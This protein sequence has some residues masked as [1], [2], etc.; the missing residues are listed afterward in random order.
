LVKGVETVY[1]IAEM[2]SFWIEELTV[3]VYL[4]SPGF[5]MTLYFRDIV[6]HAMYTTNPLGFMSS[7][8]TTAIASES[9]EMAVAI[10]SS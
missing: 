9:E 4:T 8:S 1:D 3:G 5:F 10:D 6:H 7:S 2:I